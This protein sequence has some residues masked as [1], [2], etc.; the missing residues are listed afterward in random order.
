[1]L[2]DCYLHV[3]SKL[4]IHYVYSCVIMYY[5]LELTNDLFVV[6]PGSTGPRAAGGDVELAVV[7]GLCVHGL[8][9]DS[10]TQ[11]FRASSVSTDTGDRWNRGPRGKAQSLLM[12][13]TRVSCHIIL[14]KMS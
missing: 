6:Q 4:H 5:H 12:L 8:W 9:F 10:P 2:L 1:M 13:T 3:F 11:R 14:M 7:P